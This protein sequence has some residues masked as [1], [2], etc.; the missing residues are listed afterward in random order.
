MSMQSYHRAWL[1]AHPE[2]T[3]DWLKE[4]MRDGFDIH[5]LD[6]NHAND[7]PINLVLIECGDHLMLHNGSKRVSRVVNFQKPRAIK[8]L[9]ELNSK[10]RLMH[11]FLMGEAKRLNR[12]RRK[13]VL[14]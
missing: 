8:P 13:M 2:R 14:G 9:T 5:H 3:E 11:N 7:D 12:E 4:R 6:G 10:E 1:S